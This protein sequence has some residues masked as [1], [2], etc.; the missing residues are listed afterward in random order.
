MVLACGPSCTAVIERVLE[1]VEF[2][3]QCF[4]VCLAVL[5]LEH[6]YT[7]ERLEET[8]SMALGLGIA[9]P[10]CAYIEPILK[11]GQD[12]A[13]DRDGGDGDDDGASHVRGASHYGGDE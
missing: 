11:T 3:E 7:R 12:Q 8:C 1:S 13:L 2:D 5:R 10:R 9:S 4:N 6:R